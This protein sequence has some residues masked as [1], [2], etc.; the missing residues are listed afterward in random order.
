MF[1][2]AMLPALWQLAEQRAAF[3]RTRFRLARFTGYLPAFFMAMAIDMVIIIIVALA[4][5]E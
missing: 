3:S 2:P 5:S 4:A 1:H